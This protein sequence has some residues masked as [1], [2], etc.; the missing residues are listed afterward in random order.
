MKVPFLDLNRIHNPLKNEFVE[1][2]TEHIDK[3]DFI[4]GN[5]VEE[6]EK[7]FASYCGTSHAIG[8]AN[9]LQAL[10]IILRAM[11]IGPGDEV[12]TVAN[13]FNA[14]VSSIVAVGAKPVLVDSK[15]DFTI[16]SS[17]IKGKLTN[18]TKA[19]MPVHL[20]GQACD[21]DEI[22][23]IAKENNLYVIED[24]CQSHGAIYKNKRAG[25]LGHAA[26]FSFYPGKNLGAFGDG[27]LITTNDSN[28]AQRIRMIRNYGQSKKYHHDISGINSRLD[29]MQASVLR[30]KLKHL[31]NWNSQRKKIADRYISSLKGIV[32]LPKTS[33]DRDHIYH[34]FVIR[35][36]KRDELMDYLKQNGVDSGLH[37]PIPIHLQKTFSNLSHKKR[38][39]PKSEEYSDTILSL[40]IFPGMTNEEADHVISQ[41]KSFFNAS[42][43]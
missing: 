42:L 38:D 1:K 13:T 5:P 4:L 36:N 10:E 41:I 39:F 22:M 21:M 30:I 12:I 18:K 26:A 28:L 37:Y 3:N 23:N 15:D 2:L 35:T 33:P 11:D 40:P 43:K 25:N 24:A 8:V 29:T 32:E 14:T 9:G 6:F 20:Y 34:L 16:D 7:E 27:G 17:Q 31:D 19:I